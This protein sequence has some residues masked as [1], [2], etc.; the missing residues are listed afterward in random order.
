METQNAKVRIN[1]KNGR[2]TFTYFALFPQGRWT[3]IYWRNYKNHYS[4]TCTY[5][6][7]FD[8]LYCAET[9]ELAF[10]I[11][12]HEFKSTDPDERKKELADIGAT[13]WLK[14]DRSINIYRYFEE[15]P[16][17][18]KFYTAC[19]TEVTSLF[20]A[21]IFESR[22]TIKLDRSNRKTATRSEFK[23]IQLK[24]IKNPRHEILLD[25][26]GYLRLPRETLQMGK[27]V[28]VDLD[29]HTQQVTLT[30]GSEG[31]RALKKDA[32]LNIKTLLRDRGIKITQK[33]YM[34]YLIKNDRIVFNLNGT[35]PKLELQAF[36]SVTRALGVFE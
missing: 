16:E 10:E 27:R 25:P 29:P 13:L 18:K 8:I 26:A 32:T 33:L 35:D 22:I 17:L 24:R 15:I 2:V 28:K 3:E 6:L 36:R 9:S 19:P 1:P 4:P 21:Q 20:N 14:K 23:K 5:T 7:G 11:Y 31:E 34:P 12:R 30:F